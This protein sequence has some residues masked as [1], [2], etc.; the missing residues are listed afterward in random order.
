MKLNKIVSLLTLVPLL[1]FGQNPTLVTTTNGGSNVGGRKTGN[2][3]LNFQDMQPLDGLRPWL[4]VYNAGGFGLTNIGALRVNASFDA[5]AGSVLT[6]DGL[7]GIT[8]QPSSGNLLST[9]NLFTGVN[10]F[11]GVVTNSGSVT[12]T[13]TNFIYQAG[14]GGARDHGRLVVGTNSLIVGDSPSVGTG[15][16]AIFTINTGS[17]DGL[18]WNVNANGGSLTFVANTPTMREQFLT[19]GTI[20]RSALHSTQGTFTWKDGG[21]QIMARFSQH[22]GHIFGRDGNAISN[23]VYTSA[24][25]NFATIEAFA[26]SNL[27]VAVPGVR[28]GDGVIPSWPTNYSPIVWNMSVTSNGFVN[29]FGFNPTNGPVITVSYPFNFGVTAVIRKP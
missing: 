1:A 16:N 7:G 3:I 27:P 23:I 17:G 18:A 20:Q 28:V 29:I 2:V 25:L 9:D 12:M 11:S 6:T 8:L 5:A 15:T 14:G 4:G 13:D 22:L 10:M 21:D 26:V 24:T 19:S